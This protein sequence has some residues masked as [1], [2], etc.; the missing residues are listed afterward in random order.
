M[1]HEHFETQLLTPAAL[2]HVT[3][4][5]STPT[6]GIDTTRGA[7]EQMSFLQMAYETAEGIHAA[8]DKSFCLSLTCSNR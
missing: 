6:D 5:D 7:P 1:I 3:E 8:G 2:S 4:S